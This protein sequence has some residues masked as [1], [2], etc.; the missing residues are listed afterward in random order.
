M[1]PHP[2]KPGMEMASIYRAEYGRCVATLTRLL[3]DVDITEEADEGGYR[4]T[5][6]VPEDALELGVGDARHVGGDRS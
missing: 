5:G 2:G 1:N 3:G 6:L 4:A